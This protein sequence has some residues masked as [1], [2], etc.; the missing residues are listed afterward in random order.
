M[1]K[2]ICLL[3]IGVILLVCAL[4]SLAAC[5]SYKATALEKVGNPN[6]KVESNGGLVVKQGGYLYF[7]NGYTDYLTENAKDNWFGTPVKGAI[8]RVSYGADGNLGNDYVIVV[9]KTV[10]AS[11]ENVGFS[12]FGEWIYYVSPSAEIDR[13]GNVQTDTLQ[14]MRTKIDGT[15]TQVILEVDNT[16]VKYKY[17]SSALVWYDS[18]DSKLYSKDL[19]VKRFKK[20]AKGDCIAEDVASVHFIKNET[21]DPAVKE[22]PVADYV[23]YTK[24][25]EK[26]Y[27]NSNT[28]YAVAPRGGEAKALIGEN[29]YTDG[30]YNISVLA[31]SVSANAL[32]IYYT[33]T[34]YVG[35][36]SSGTVV[37]T[38][39]YR[40]AA[41]TALAGVVAANE[42]R[43]SASDLSSIVPISYTEGVVKTGSNTVIYHTD[44]TDP[45]TFGDLDV[46]T[47]LAVENGAFYYLN[48]D[49]VILYYPLDNL[50][51]AHF[52]YT[53]GEKVM[54]SFTGAEYFEGYFYFIVDDDYDYMHRVKLSDIDVYSGKDAAVTRVAILS[55]ADKAKMEEEAEKSDSDK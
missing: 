35:T 31:S 48:S 29:T 9:P 33:K 19:S 11:S 41:G 13:S 38:Y 30:K 32:A 7:V 42:V 50:S 25:S 22:T 24:N 49:N 46:S 36:S 18:A 10:M 14:F 43:L 26:S 27:D 39:A 51:N 16:S 12:I 44:G 6:D 28:L 53:T 15:G 4:A 54:T 2:K 45:S 21:Y 1:R 34:S 47:L 40:F 5:E 3:V 8:V 17:T 20:S 55:D 37:G 23:L 52:A